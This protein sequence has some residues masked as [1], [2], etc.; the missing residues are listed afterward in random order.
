MCY[1][2]LKK[3]QEAYDSCQQR[4]T[5]YNEVL[6]RG[7]F[8]SS[9]DSDTYVRVVIPVRTASSHQQ[10]WSKFVQPLVMIF[11]SLTNRHPQKIGEDKL[12]FLSYYFCSAIMY[13]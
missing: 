5:K 7:E 9:D 6:I 1:S 13:Y 11:V 2:Q 4:K 3:Q 12:C 8:L 10:K